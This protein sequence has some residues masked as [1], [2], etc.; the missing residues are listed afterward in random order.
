MMGFCSRSLM[1]SLEKTKCSFPKKGFALAAVYAT[2]Y[3][4]SG[5]FALKISDTIVFSGQG[6]KTVRLNCTYDTS[7][8]RTSKAIQMPET[9]ISDFIIVDSPNENPVTMAF[10]SILSNLPRDVGAVCLSDVVGKTSSALEKEFKMGPQDAVTA[11]EYALGK[12]SGFGNIRLFY[13]FQG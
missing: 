9:E 7:T 11:C 8:L 1:L 2:K 6:E 3:A 13:K 10:C 12:N 5:I 4:S